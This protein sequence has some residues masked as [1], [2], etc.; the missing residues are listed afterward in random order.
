MA[1]AGTA[2]QP[3]AG[4]PAEPDPWIHVLKLPCQLTLE[5]PLPDFTVGTLMHLEPGTV[6]DSH[7]NVSDDLPL[8]VNGEVIAWSEFEVVANRLAVRLT[9]LA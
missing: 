8:R 1:A 2:P 7:W 9:E 6:I 4:P 5:L 3:E